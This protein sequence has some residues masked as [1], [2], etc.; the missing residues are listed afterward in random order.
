MDLFLMYIKQGDQKTI[1]NMLLKKRIQLTYLKSI[2][3]WLQYSIKT[4]LCIKKLLLI[5]SVTLDVLEWNLPS[6]VIYQRKYRN[7][8]KQGVSFKKV[9][10]LRYAFQI[11]NDLNVLHEMKVMHQ[12]IKSA[13]IFLIN[14][15]VKLGD[16]NVSKVIKEGLLYT[17]TGK[18]YYASSEVWK[19][20]PYDCKSDIWL[21]GCVLFE[22][23]ALKL[24]FQ[25]QDMD[26][27]YKKGQYKKLSKSFSQDLHNLI[28]MMLYISTSLRPNISQLLQ[29]TCFQK[30]S[31]LTQINSGQ[32]IKT[33]LFPIIKVKKNLSKTYIQTQT[34]STEFLSIIFIIM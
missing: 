28:R 26:N 22:I 8:Q 1:L 27:L 6:M 24:P 16:L 34:R 23:T 2:E 3:F 4:L 29:F 21:L 5:K 17:Q 7:T 13:K 30:F 14:N 33:I 25:A 20:H 32:L 15:D 10:F 12:D 19:D 11:L 9:K 31:F 18:P